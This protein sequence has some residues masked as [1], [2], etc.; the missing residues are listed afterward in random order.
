M[1]YNF[2]LIQNYFLSIDRYGN[3][4]SFN[5]RGH[6]TYQT[7]FGS[8]M[9][10]ISYI[11]LLFF[12][13]M[14]SLE[15]IYHNKP[16]III[17][18]LVDDTPLHHIL[19]N[20]FI[21]AIS[22]QYLNYSNYIDE[23]IYTLN[24]FVSISNIDKNGIRNETKINLNPIKCSN[25][26]RDGVPEYFNIL[27]LDNLYCVNLT[28]FK[29]R[30][31]YL[32]DKWTSIN[33]EFKKCINSTKIKNCKTSDEI[34]NILKGGYVGIFATDYQILPHNY[35]NP[36]KIY[37]QNLYTSFS[38][39]EY[40]DFWVYYQI[41]QINTDK[42]L[43]FD[44]IFSEKYLTYDSFSVSR[45]FRKTNNFLTV[46]LR[47]TQNRVIIDRTYTKFQ[48]LAAKMGGITKLI[49]I[50]GELISFFFTKILYKNFI[51]Q[52]FNLEESNFT[53]NKNKGNKNNFIYLQSSELLQNKSL[54]NTNN[55]PLLI[56]NK[57]EIKTKF[58]LKNKIQ[59]FSDKNFEH[60]S[61]EIKNN[62]NKINI[63]NNNNNFNK[64]IRFKFYKKSNEEHIICFM[65]ILCKKNSFQ[66][67]K[68]IYLT[69]KKIL[70]LFDII[71]Y[72]KIFHRIN[73][74]EKTVFTENERKDINKIY[75]IDYDFK[76]DKNGADYLLGR[77]KIKKIMKNSP[78]F[79]IN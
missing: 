55:L 56:L 26:F 14:F 32:E 39:D 28:G 68:E 51:L 74:L 40:V 36:A 19:S 34:Y 70:F 15:I 71:Q 27:Y 77:T 35:K 72:I 3:K 52:F 63:S 33:F 67:I 31:V 61:S 6:K 5:I 50:V 2:E 49:F 79:N 25:Y 57:N 24:A 44:S 76:L 29:L 22:L 23:T 65:K 30:G 46:Y 20:K 43:I 64:F 12:L 37:R 7:I 11:L 8:I 21:F 45:D 75:H 42:G 47:E 73:F 54:S 53:K 59:R 78:I 10:I 9:T 16:N 13:Y 41:K 62:S 66:K 48:N 60:L 38:I 69:F 58:S 17:T 1:K 4:P 18:Y